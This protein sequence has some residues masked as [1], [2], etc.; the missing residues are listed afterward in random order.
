[1]RRRASSTGSTVP[2]RRPAARRIGARA[3]TP[4]PGSARS[5]SA[6]CN[7]TTASATCSSSTM[8]VRFTREAP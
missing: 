1:M 3:S 8:N 4:G 7:R 5:S 6:V 2:S